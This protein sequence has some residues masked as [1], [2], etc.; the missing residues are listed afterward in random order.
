MNI[1]GWFPLGLTSLILLNQPWVCIQTLPLEPPSHLLPLPELRHLKQQI[2]ELPGREAKICEWVTEYNSERSHSHLPNL[3]PESMCSGTWRQYHYSILQD[4]ILSLKVLS[5]NWHHNW[6][7]SKQFHCEARAA[8]SRWWNLWQDL[9][10]Y[11]CK[12]TQFSSVS[13]SCLTLCDAMDCSMPGFPVHHQLLEFTQTPVHW[14][15]DA[16][17]PTHPLLP[18]SPLAFNLS[19][20]QDLYKW[21]RSLH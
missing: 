12:F 20:H 15:S 17:Q 21:V 14:V 16:I 9:L 3:I 11:R 4:T 19:Q 13:Q 10:I 8:S 7:S 18:P 2:S 1:Q 6:V 5:H